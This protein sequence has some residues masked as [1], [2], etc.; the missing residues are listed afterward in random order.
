M[1]RVLSVL[2]ASSASGDPFLGHPPWLVVIVLTIVAALAIWILAKLLKWTLRLLF[3][4]VLIGG[5]AMA[6][7]LL[8]GKPPLA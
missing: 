2:Q 6:L 8:L 7:W 1:A 5:F 3:V 4:A